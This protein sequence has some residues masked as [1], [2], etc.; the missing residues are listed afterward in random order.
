M[1]KIDIP[2]NLYEDFIKEKE[3]LDSTLSTIEILK[4]KEIL[5]E[6]DKGNLEIKNKKSKTLSF[7]EIDNL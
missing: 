2:N 6:I 4:D 7:D 1:V 3:D 5:K